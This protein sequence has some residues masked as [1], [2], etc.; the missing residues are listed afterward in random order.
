MVRHA[1]MLF[2]IAAA[3]AL[4]PGQSSAQAK[5]LEAKVCLNCHKSE[6][7]N[8]RG[9]YEGAAFKSR[10]MQLKID[11]ATEILSFDPATL[12]VIV[13]EKMADAEA[14]REIKKGHEVRIAF[15]EKDGQKT[16]TLVSSKP[17][18]KLP[19]EW[20][21]TT[22]EVTAL[23]AQGPDKGKY[24]L[25]DS[26]PAPRFYEGA[27]PTAINIPYPAFDANRDKLPN[28]KGRLL[29]FYCGGIT[30]TMSPK[31]AEKAKALGYANLRVYHEGMPD[32]VKKNYSV[33]SAHSLNS[34][35]IKN[36]IPHVLLDVRP[37]SKAKKG[38][39]P[40]AVTFPAADADKLLAKLPPVDKKPPVMVYD[41]EGGTDAMDVARK[42]VNA[43]YK[44]TSVVTGG[45]DLWDN[46]NYPTKRGSLA[47]EAVYVPKP[48]PGEMS[49]DE[50][51][52]IAES[53]PADTLILDVRNTDEANAGM[54]RG[55]KLVPDEEIL[56]RLAEI[57]KDKKIVTH[58][59]TGVRAEMAYHKLKDKGYNVRFLNARIDIDKQG[60][61]AI[62]KE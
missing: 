18:V 41:Q 50:F 23:V 43:G 51:K 5:A 13:D 44:K 37:E 52:K 1:G 14:L 38:F 28:D 9:H 3:I 25:V 54:I 33:I 62:T 36:D 24:T 57:P 8:L 47:S 27:I 4:S 48:R 6:A 56:G 49:V 11:D 20:M 30:C 42:L 17:P 53:T 35:Y 59:A 2:L 22:D 10:S 45:Y 61:P 26:R 31:S 19:A 32:W 40:G 58:C 34:A 29:I 21:I 39:I 12:K 7:G 46:S 15:I 16:A 60:N 55:A